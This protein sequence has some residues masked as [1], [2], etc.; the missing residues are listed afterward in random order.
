MGVDTIQETYMVWVSKQGDDEMTN[1]IAIGAY[2]E[3]T[4]QQCRLVHIGDNKL[5]TYRRT[6]CADGLTDYKA[7]DDGEPKLMNDAMI[8]AFP[9]RQN[10]VMSI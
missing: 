9:A 7:T 8:A 10:G 5:Q 1:Q 4:A 2:I 6:R 3:M